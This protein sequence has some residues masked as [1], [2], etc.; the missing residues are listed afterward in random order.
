MTQILNIDNVG[1]DD[2]T[3]PEDKDADGHCCLDNDVGFSC[4]KERRIHCDLNDPQHFNTLTD[5]QKKKLCEWIG[6]TLCH[7]ITINKNHTSYGLKHIFE[8]SRNGFYVTNGTF[9]GAMLE[10]GF[11]KH[12]EGLNWSFCVTERSAR[13]QGRQGECTND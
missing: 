10:C 6:A 4:M 1:Y 7:R 12:S 3:K 5:I 2:L 9:K 8:H 11:T 13:R